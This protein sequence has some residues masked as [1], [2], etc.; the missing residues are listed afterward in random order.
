MPIF[1]RD[2]ATPPP[3]ITDRGGY[4]VYGDHLDQV[5]DDIFTLDRLSQVVLYKQSR[6][7]STDYV[8]LLHPQRLLIQIFKRLAMRDWAMFGTQRWIWMMGF[9]AVTGTL[10]SQTSTDCVALLACTIC[11]DAGAY[12]RRFSYDTKDFSCYNDALFSPSSKTELS[13]YFS[14]TGVTVS[15]AQ[16]SFYL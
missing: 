5:L 6:A 12:A 3:L 15:E 8:G 14:L 4:D 11:E 16:G 13:F 1:C 2:F 9:P 7:L 10:G